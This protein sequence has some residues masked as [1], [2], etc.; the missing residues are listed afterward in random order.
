[1]LTVRLLSAKSVSGFERDAQIVLPE[2]RCSK[3]RSKRW[4]HVT[5]GLACAM[6]SKY[7]G[8]LGGSVGEV[9]DFS[10]GQDFTVHE[11]EP[12]FGLCADSSEPGA[13]LGFCISLSLPLPHSC[14]V[15]VSLSQCLSLKK[16]PPEEHR[17]GGRLRMFQGRLLWRRGRPAQRV[18]EGPVCVLK[19]PGFYRTPVSL[20]GL[21]VF[22]SSPFPPFHSMATTCLPRAQIESY[23]APPEKQVVA[24]PSSG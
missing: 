24:S 18:L 16:A 5:A 4:S 22:S 3:H 19:F 12:H 8:R 21:P 20:R 17:L 11:F 23:Q 15:S 1:M 7:Q 10:S 6:L 13:S 9:S 2:V 14:S